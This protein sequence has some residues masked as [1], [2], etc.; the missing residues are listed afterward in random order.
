MRAQVC[1]LLGKRPNRQARVVSF[2]HKRHKTVQ[3]VNLHWKKY[4]SEKLGR[5][6]RMRLSTKGMKTVTKY[7]SI[8]AAAEAK[9]I[10]ISKF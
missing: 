10:D 4:Y 1:D 2:S 5:K 6:V 7:G 8:D 3:Y 9:G